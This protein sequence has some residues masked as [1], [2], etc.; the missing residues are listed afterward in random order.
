M[1]AIT[2][3]DACPH[4]TPIPLGLITWCAQCGKNWR[5][6]AATDFDPRVTISV[7]APTPVP[8]PTTEVR[9]TMALIEAMG[10]QAK[11]QF[12][13]IHGDVPFYRDDDFQALLDRYKLRR[14]T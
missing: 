1:V 2:F 10:M 5:R 8:G 7:D 6:P 3:D 9:A 14:P 4:G 11:N 12:C 13:V